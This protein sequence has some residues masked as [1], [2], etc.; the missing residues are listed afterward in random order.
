MEDTKK[1]NSLLISNAFKYIFKDNNWKY[2]FAIL[3]LLEFPY[4][5]F[6]YTIQ[7]QKDSLGM[8]NK[9]ALLIF[10]LI[11]M[12]FAIGYIAKC[13]HNIIVSA[14]NLNLMLFLLGKMQKRSFGLIQDGI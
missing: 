5:Y 14:M 2:K 7:F 10:S 13:T 3:A 1:I 6:A 9:L 12:P 8:L 4:W 11:T